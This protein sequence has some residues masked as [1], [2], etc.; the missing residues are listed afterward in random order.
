ML[1]SARILKS[2][3]LSATKFSEMFDLILQLVFMISLGLIVYL[4]AVAVPRIDEQELEADTGMTPLGR[5]LKNLPLE[6]IDAAFS[7]SRDKILRRLKVLIMKA[8]NFVS[9]RLNNKENQL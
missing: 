2:E 7:A 9:H 6:R 5:W 3:D 1:K 8:D 4:I